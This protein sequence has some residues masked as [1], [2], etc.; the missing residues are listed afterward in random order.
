MSERD[1]RLD[2]REL[3]LLWRLENEDRADE[4]VELEGE[5]V[6]S[7]F[8]EVLGGRSYLFEHGSDI[9]AATEALNV[10]DAELERYETV[11]EARRAF[12]TRVEE[13]AQE[14]KI[15]DMDAD[16]NVGDAS[17]GPVLTEAGEE[18]LED[19]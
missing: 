17:E 13:L 7:L 11:A 15:V 5:R 10:G 1:D 19:A 18:N 2:Q 9:E 8:L 4:R 6:L 3:A 16:E 12:A 14:Q